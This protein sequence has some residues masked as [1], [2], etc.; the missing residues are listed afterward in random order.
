MSPETNRPAP[1]LIALAGPSEGATLTLDRLE[2][3][4]GRDRRNR[5]VLADASVSSR[6]CVITSQKGQVTVRD[7]DPANPSIINGLP[8]SGRTLGPADRLRIG[9][10]TFTLTSGA[11]EPVAR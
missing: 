7:L 1:V 5:L 11:S 10:S 8:A 3:S 6:H 4:V 2:T 9:G